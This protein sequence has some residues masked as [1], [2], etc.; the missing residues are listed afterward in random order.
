MGGHNF[1]DYISGTDVGQAY[2]KAVADA[3]EEHGHSS[4][5]GTVS[6]TDGYLVLDD[7][8][9]PLNEAL[10]IARR[11]IDDPRIE[12]GGYCGAIPV[13]STRRDIF[14]AIPAKPGGYLTRDEAADA[15]LAPHLREGE[16]VDRYYLQVDAVHHADTGRIVSGSVRAPVEGG[17]ATHAGWLFFGMAAS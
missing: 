4:Y 2:E 11:K 5:N 9:R 15:A 12:K 8:P 7:T 1:E 10:E 6:T 13:L 3:I 16:T 14:A 17:E